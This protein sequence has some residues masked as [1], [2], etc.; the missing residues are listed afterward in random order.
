MKFKPKS[1]NEKKTSKNPQNAMGKKLIV[2]YY[3]LT[4]FHNDLL[5]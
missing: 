2:I 3:L 4:E 5:S 1:S